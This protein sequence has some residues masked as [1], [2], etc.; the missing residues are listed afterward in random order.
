VQASR[1]GRGRPP[2]SIRPQAVLAAL[3]ACVFVVLLFVGG[4][5]PERPKPSSSGSNSVSR[6]PQPTSADELRR[7]SA[8]ASQ[9]IFW[10]GEQ[11]RTKLELT[12]TATG[13]IFVRYLPASAQIG[14]PSLAYPFVATYKYP[15]AFEA[16]Q[17]AAGTGGSVVRKL[18]AG[19][20]AVQ[21]RRG[22]ELVRA[23]RQPL[24]APP[25][26]LAYPGSDFLI[27]VYDRSTDRALGLVTSGRVRPVR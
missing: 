24:P 7:L 20:L 4:G 9:P 22:P 2:L 26:F 19:G 8:T 18:P 23:T 10:L 11:P 3:A 14:D 25:V 13:R 27:E 12:R 15:R 17:K 5:P 1:V 16:V 6:A 21:S